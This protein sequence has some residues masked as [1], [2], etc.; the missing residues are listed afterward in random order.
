MD[1]DGAKFAQE[2][3]SS[4]VMVLYYTT[5]LKQKDQG[6]LEVTYSDPLGILPITPKN[7]LYQ[8]PILQTIQQKKRRKGKN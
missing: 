4:D 1:Q 3:A 8:I 7:I 2:V 6:E 5:Y